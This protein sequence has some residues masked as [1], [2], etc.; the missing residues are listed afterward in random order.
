MAMRWDETNHTKYL[1]CYRWP[2]II[3]KDIDDSHLCYIRNQDHRGCAWFILPI[4]IYTISVFKDAVLGHSPFLQTRTRDKKELLFFLVSSRARI[5]C[6]TVSTLLL[7][8]YKIEQ[9]GRI[10]QFCIWAG[11]RTQ[12]RQ[13]DRQHVWQLAL[14][15][16]SGYHY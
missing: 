7:S 6:H 12:N 11:F 4:G 14:L 1:T 15:L 5:S 9:R 16:S 8:C 2:I 13:T 10:F 3:Y